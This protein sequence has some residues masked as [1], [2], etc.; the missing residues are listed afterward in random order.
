MKESTTFLIVRYKYTYWESLVSFFLIRTD[1]RR[2]NLQVGN[3]FIWFYNLDIYLF[4]SYNYR[5][6]SGKTI[7]EEKQENYRERWLSKM[8]PI[9]DVCE[10]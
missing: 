1:D 5:A 2:L 10:L 8:C 3:F 4:V 7:S 6:E 9:S